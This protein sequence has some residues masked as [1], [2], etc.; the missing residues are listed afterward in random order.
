MPLLRWTVQKDRTMHSPSHSRPEHLAANYGR[1][2]SMLIAATSFLRALPLF[3]AARPKTPLRVLCIAAFDTLHVLRTSNRLPVRR[4]RM[5]AALLDFGASANAAFDRKKFCPEEFRCTRQLL[6]EA[7]IG[8]TVD[9]YWRRIQEL[10]RRRP[11][12]GGN[13]LDSQRVRTYREDVV[14]LSL[15]V[16]TTTAFVRGSLEDGIQSIQA[17]DDLA[18]LFAIVMQ[19]QIIDDVVDYSKDVTADLPGFLTASESLLVAFELTCLAT[20][21]YASDRGLARSGRE[22]PFR[23]ALFA[24]SVI[25]K[26]LINLG[27]WR[28]RIPFTM[29]MARS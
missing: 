9:E 8:S 27:R 10:E 28:Q 24:V 3:I 17:E 22:F 15:G 5:L 2:S 13:R 14:R 25:A 7:G 16:L 23:F 18:V 11:C 19:C 4:I 20:R 6:E 21:C 26:L 12:P 29:A 1:I